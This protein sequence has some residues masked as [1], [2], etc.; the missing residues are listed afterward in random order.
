MALTRVVPSCAGDGVTETPAASSAVILLCAV[1]FPPEMMAPAW[2][3]LR[4]GGAV[5]PAMKDTTG[6]ALGP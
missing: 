6:F 4:P 3:I 2:P 5:T 1:P